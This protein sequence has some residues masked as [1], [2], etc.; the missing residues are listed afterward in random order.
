MRTQPTRFPELVQFKGP[1]GLSAALAAAAD[2]EHTS[3]AEFI[4]RTLFARLRE[5]GFSLNSGDQKA[6]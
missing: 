6:A 3:M 5:G 4:R 2:E 1:A